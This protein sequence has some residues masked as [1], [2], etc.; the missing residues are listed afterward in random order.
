MSGLGALLRA[1]FPLILST[2]VGSIL[3][4]GLSPGTFFLPRIA[5]GFLL[6]DISPPVDLKSFSIC[7]IAAGGGLPPFTDGLP[8]W[9]SLPVSFA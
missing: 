9:G 3:T 1:S 6:E 8:V 5:I 2:G 7:L 4:F